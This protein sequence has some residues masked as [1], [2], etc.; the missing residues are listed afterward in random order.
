MVTPLK[1]RVE[2]NSQNVNDL[3]RNDVFALNVYKAGNL[4]E[5]YKF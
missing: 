3:L 2:N 1:F 4:L 5:G